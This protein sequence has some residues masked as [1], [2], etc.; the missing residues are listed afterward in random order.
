[1]PLTGQ[2]IKFVL[3]RTQAD[4]FYLYV[5]CHHVVIDVFGLALV[6]QRIASVYSAIV[7]GAP[8]PPSI[9]GSLRDLIDCESEY[10]ASNDYL[11]DQAYSVTRLQ[12]IPFPLSI[13]WN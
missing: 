12:E 8:I 9:F 4:E 3:F 13:R 6:C 7:S 2:L 11:E 5:C 1:M 10:E